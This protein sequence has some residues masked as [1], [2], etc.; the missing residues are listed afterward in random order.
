MEYPLKLTI[1]FK[2]PL[3]RNL[4][5]VPAI[6]FMLLIALLLSP[7]TYA[8][9]KHRYGFSSGAMLGHFGGSGMES[10]MTGVYLEAPTYSFET[11][12]GMLLGVKR[13]VIMMTTTK[14]FSQG[15][16]QYNLSVLTLAIGFSYSLSKT[17][18]IEPCFQSGSGNAEFR[19]VSDDENKQ[20]QIHNG[21]GIINAL[22]IPIIWEFSDGFFLGAQY[23]GFTG[24]SNITGED[25]FRAQIDPMHG[26][27]F[28]IGAYY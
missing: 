12:F 20:E 24:G 21:T 9:Y 7:Y 26:L 19:Y 17:L 5:T 23:I 3:N 4:K 11:D 22:V 14:E 1:F 10:D 15:K 2:T 27:Q 6:L 8:E 25:G 16:V 18:H 28:S 13:S